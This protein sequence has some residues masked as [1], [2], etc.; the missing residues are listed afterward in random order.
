MEVR[1]PYLNRKY[2]FQFNHANTGLLPF[3]KVKM[4]IKLLTHSPWTPKG[5][6][7]FSGTGGRA[8]AKYVLFLTVSRVL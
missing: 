5:L 4:S 8:R 2:I 6:G 1:C 3:V 7:Q